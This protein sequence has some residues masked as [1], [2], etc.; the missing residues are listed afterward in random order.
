MLWQLRAAGVFT[1]V[2][3]VVFNQLPGCDEPGAGVSSLDAVRH[4]LTGVAG[5]VVA[6]V[7]SGHTAD[8]MLTLPF[9]V[10]VSLRA[11]DDV[12]LSIDEAAVA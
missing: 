4:A 2:T 8:A 10:Q 12:S 3:G 1:H 5:P 9:G 6:G 11:G 7:P